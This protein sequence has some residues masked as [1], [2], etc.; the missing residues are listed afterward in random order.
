MVTSIEQSCLTST[1]HYD[2]FV[3]QLKL[4]VPSRASAVPSCQ[5]LYIV[6]FGGG[7]VEGDNVAVDI[8][9]GENC[10]VVATTQASTKVC[11]KLSYTTVYIG[12]AFRQINQLD[13]LRCQRSRL[14]SNSFHIYFCNIVSKL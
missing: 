12:L 10:T 14:V 6:T 1:V 8:K 13:L 5:W 2:V 4:L 3:T 9:V 7:L 11:T